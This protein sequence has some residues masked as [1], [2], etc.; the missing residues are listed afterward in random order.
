MRKILNA[1]IKSSFLLK[2]AKLNDA[3]FLQIYKS[4]KLKAKLEQVGLLDDFYKILPEETEKS[5]KEFYDIYKTEDE[6]VRPKQIKDQTIL[7]FLKEFGDQYLD[8]K[9]NKFIPRYGLIIR[10]ESAGDVLSTMTE[11][12]VRKIKEFILDYMQTPN[13][14]T[15]IVN[16]FIN[17]YKR[18]LK[19]Q[20]P[21]AKSFLKIKTCD[22]LYNMSA[23][24]N[25]SKELYD[26]NYEKTKKALE[27]RESDIFDFVLQGE[28][29]P[30]IK[31]KE[32]QEIIPEK[33]SVK[34]DYT[35]E[36][37]KK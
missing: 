31:Q 4:P 36:A 20:E 29:T 13:A 24:I 34:T 14:T 33:P 1:Y 2:L 12:S 7:D 28:Q 22:I 32:E 18:Y 30:R 5:I 21:K 16:N 15:N 17:R 8:N 6:N 25:V 9:I 26:I 19:E 10:R 27:L 11:Y 23:Y 35:D 3:Q 37:T